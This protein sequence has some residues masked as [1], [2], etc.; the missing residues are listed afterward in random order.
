MIQWNK[1]AIQKLKLID[2]CS[3]GEL[4]L[5]ELVAEID[6]EIELFGGKL[7]WF[8]YRSIKKWNAKLRQINNRG[9]KGRAILSLNG[10]SGGMT[11]VNLHP[12]G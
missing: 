10:V 8:F 3:Y 12:H 4:W 1:R 7:Y 6:E 11:S 9:L 2:S 5:C